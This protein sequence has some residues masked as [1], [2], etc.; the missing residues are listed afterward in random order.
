MKNKHLKKL[1]H[2]EWASGLMISNI[3]EIHEKIDVN[4]AADVWKKTVGH[5]FENQY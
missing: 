1:N 3:I 5:K 2:E 4:I